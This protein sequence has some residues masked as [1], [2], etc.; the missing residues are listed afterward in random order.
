MYLPK[1]QER[2]TKLGKG[3]GILLLPTSKPSLHTAAPGS[4]PLGKTMTPFLGAH[5]QSGTTRSDTFAARW[6]AVTAS[7]ARGHRGLGSGKGWELRQVRERWSFRRW[8]GRAGREGVETGGGVQ[9]RA[10]WLADGIPDGIEWGLIGSIRQL[11]AFYL[12]SLGTELGIYC[13]LS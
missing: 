9:G 6:P 13:C 1:R 8:P 7:P 12:F 11:A 2:Y 4:S 3:I 5:P 10:F